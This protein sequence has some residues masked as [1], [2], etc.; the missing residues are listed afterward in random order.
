M[1]ARSARDVTRPGVAARLSAAVVEE[2]VQLGVE[3]IDRAEEERGAAGGRRKPMARAAMPDRT[4]SGVAPTP[5]KRCSASPTTAHTTAASP[6]QL[7]GERPGGGLV[8]GLPKT[9]D[10]RAHALH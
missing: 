4:R 2:L 8:G 9:R 1:I 3:G 10:V 6:Q 5:M 7:D